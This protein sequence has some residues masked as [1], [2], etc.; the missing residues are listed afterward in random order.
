LI[1]R[2]HLQWASPWTD[3]KEK[4]KVF[5]QKLRVTYLPAE[6]QVPGEDEEDQE[7]SF[8]PFFPSKRHGTVTLT[9]FISSKT[10]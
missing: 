7:V 3:T 8:Y 10:L 5:H 2:F 9:R 1:Q 4:G 6:G